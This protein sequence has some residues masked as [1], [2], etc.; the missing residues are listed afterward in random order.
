MKTDKTRSKKITKEYVSNKSMKH[1]DQF[2]NVMV[3]SIVFFIAVFLIAQM[4]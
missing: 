2:I 4:V 3:F 1:K